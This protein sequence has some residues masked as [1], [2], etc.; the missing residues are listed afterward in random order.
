MAKATYD[1]TTFTPASDPSTMDNIT[2]GLQAPFLNA[3]EYLDANSAWWA[4]VGYGFLG[5]AVGGFVARKRTEAGKPPI[6]KFLY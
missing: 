6:A 2:A 3:D 4:S 1:G 5:S